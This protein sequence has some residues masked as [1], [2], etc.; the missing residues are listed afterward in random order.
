MLEGLNPADASEGGSKLPPPSFFKKPF[1]QKL[2]DLE[3]IAEARGLKNVWNQVVTPWLKQT[4][5]SVVKVV[6]ASEQPASNFVCAADGDA[7]QPGQ[8]AAPSNKKT[9]E[10]LVAGLEPGKLWQE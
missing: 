2:H 5:V 8:P 1:E 4:S 6:V 3:S 10:D 7:A 9:L